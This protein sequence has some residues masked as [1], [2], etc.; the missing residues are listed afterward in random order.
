MNSTKGLILDSIPDTALWVE[1]RGML[2]SGRGSVLDIQFMPEPCGAVFQ[3][4]IGLGVV[5]GRP[6]ED[7]LYQL[8]EL[9]EE[10]LCPIENAESVAAALAQYS[11]EDASLMQIPASFDHAH[12][13]KKI[14]SASARDITELRRLELSDLEKHTNIP[15]LLHQELEQEL[16]FGTDIYCLVLGNR[17]VSFCYPANKSESLWDIS[18]DTLVEY[19]NRGL[20]EQCVR[21][22]IAEM[23]KKGVMP[24]WGAVESNTASRRLAA[25]LGFGEVCRIA[26]FTREA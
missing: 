3:E 5:I 18:I 10:I 2:L 4:D 15:D 24:V 19:R 17:P 20:A 25:K 8:S 14:D 21:Y 26:V 9:T 23:R 16:T 12:V 6:N 1:A 11:R 22:A 7:L 13:E